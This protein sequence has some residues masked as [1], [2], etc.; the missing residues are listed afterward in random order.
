MD[1]VYVGIADELERRKH[2]GR[3]ADRVAS[4][5]KWLAGKLGVSQ[6][7]VSN[8][9]TAGVPAAHHAGIA[10]ALGWSIERVVSGGSEESLQPRLSEYALE[11]ALRMDALMEGDLR[12]FRAAYMQLSD[13]LD[14]LASAA[15][16]RS[17]EPEPVATPPRA[18]H[19]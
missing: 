19:R 17:S 18:R 8:W 10:K 5:W 7:V 14:R 13:S 6:Q 3:H 16:P 4:T 11:I 1:A 9:K 12:L 15:A 2:S